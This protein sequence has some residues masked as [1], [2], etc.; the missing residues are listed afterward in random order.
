MST[1]CNNDMKVMEVTNHVLIGV[2]AWNIDAT[3][4]RAK[5]L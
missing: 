1:L 2:K 5:K 3:V 4:N